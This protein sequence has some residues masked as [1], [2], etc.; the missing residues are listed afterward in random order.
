MN[1]TYWVSSRCVTE[2]DYFRELNLVLGARD[3]NIISFNNG[4]HSFGT[5]L[6]E[7]ETA[8]QGAVQF[9]KAKCPNAKLFICNCTPLKD[10]A[11]TAKSKQLNAITQRIAEK[12]HCPVIDLFS[13]MD[14]LDRNEYWKDACHFK[15]PATEKQAQKIVETILA[16]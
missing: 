13:L 15:Q 2:R 7:W 3:Y 1:V 4:L 10:P 16:P 5:N 12:E 9:I 8:Y 11:Y 14:P 6:A